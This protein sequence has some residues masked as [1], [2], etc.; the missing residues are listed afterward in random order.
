MDQYLP[1]IPPQAS[2]HALGIDWVFWITTII[3]AAFG[4]GV[5]FFLILFTA[6][7]RE[8]RK[9][10][11]V[12][13]HHEGIALEMIWTVIPLL[14][15]IG[16]FV[17]ST[18]IVFPIFRAPREA[19]EIFVVGKQWMWKLQHPNGRWEMNELHVPVGKPVKLTMISEDVIH[20]F[21]IPAFRLNMDVVPGR[22]TTTWFTPTRV[23]RYHI[24]CAQY[25][26]TNHAIMGGYV[27]VMEPDQ[28]EKWM[29]T[30]NVSSSLA[31]KGETLFREKGCTGCHGPNA[32]LRAPSLANLYGT[33]RP[34]QIPGDQ[35]WRPEM[36]S[37]LVKADYRYL[38]DSI[39]L[40]GTEIASGYEP[41]MPS[42]AGRLTEEEVIQL[43]DYIK[44]LSTSNGTSN[45]SAQG[46]E[47]VP[48]ADSGG[49]NGATGLSDLGDARTGRRYGGS[50][51]GDLA[52]QLDRE[53]IYAPPFALGQPG[54]AA[55]GKLYGGSPTGD[56]ANQRDRET[57]FRGGGVAPG[58]ATLDRSAGGMRSQTAQRPGLGVY[59]TEAYKRSTTSAYTGG[60][61]SQQPG[62]QS[63]GNVP[64][65][66]GAAPGRARNSPPAQSGTVPQEQRR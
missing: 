65:A 2:N 48:G 27:T 44:T 62:A 51:T 6:R 11:R 39:I 37:Q 49:L 14:I 50:P 54:D 32:N 42:Y 33:E 25:C 8:G 66:L 56:M 47:P 53:A 26:G 9:V 10:N 36:P 63:K 18:V 58:T 64:S 17:I 55:T 24:F 4:I 30:G 35:P 34:V 21:G 3:V 40:P 20:S 23:G 41:I 19:S 7:Y 59:E 28:F 61:R 12:L 38:H 52:N 13:P 29:S 31:A 57:I 43:V 60:L 15:V 1:F 46:Y 5:A 45:G 22:Y 16:L